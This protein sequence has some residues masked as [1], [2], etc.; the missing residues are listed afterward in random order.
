M[1]DFNH[2]LYSTWYMMFSLRCLRPRTHWQQSRPYQ[3][4][5]W[6]YRQQ[7][8]PSWRQCWP[9]QAVEFKLL[10]ICRQNRQQSWPNR[11]QS[12]LLPICCR[13]RQQS[14]LS[15]AC[16]GLNITPTISDNLHH[17]HWSWPI[18]S[19]N[20]SINQSYIDYIGLTAINFDMPWAVSSD[21]MRVWLGAAS[22]RCVSDEDVSDED[23][24]DEDNE[25]SVHWLPPDLSQCTDKRVLQLVDRVRLDLL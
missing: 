2:W 11:Q 8:R 6:P 12:T 13:F 1:F 25:N 18:Q 20:Q 24:S 15:P 3:Q 23:A 4:Q 16:T 17:D 14:T 21:V 5:S 7:R 19:I 9:R 10:P 22:R